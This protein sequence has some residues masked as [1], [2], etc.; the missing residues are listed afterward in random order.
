MA[1]TATQL[2]TPENRVNRAKLRLIELSGGSAEKLCQLRDT[3]K[4]SDIELRCELSYLTQLVNWGGRRPVEVC[5]AGH[6]DDGARRR[7]FSKATLQQ[8]DDGVVIDIYTKVRTPRAWAIPFSVEQ[9]APTRVRV[10]KETGH[11]AA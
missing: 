1:R 3:D 6:P 8:D 7:V 10:K 4:N 5:V 11:V 9:A 2:L